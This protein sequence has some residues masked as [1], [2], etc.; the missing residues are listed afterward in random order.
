MSGKR[1][2]R[3]HFAV[4]VRAKWEHPCVRAPGVGVSVA[5]GM[6][7]SRLGVLHIFILHNTSDQEEKKMSERGRKI[8]PAMKETT[9]YLTPLAPRAVE[10]DSAVA[11]PA[12]LEYI[13][14]PISRS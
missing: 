10:V 9:L 1:R 13:S 7:N 6:R 2:V 11:V 3:T 14:W 8:P 4:V 12:C 5:G